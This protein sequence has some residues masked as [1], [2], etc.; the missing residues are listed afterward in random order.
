[1]VSLFAREKRPVHGQRAQGRRVHRGSGT[2]DE[3][4]AH[5]RRARAVCRSACVS[6]L[7]DAKSNHA[8]I[9]KET[10]TWFPLQKTKQEFVWR[11]VALKRCQWPNKAVRKRGVR[12]LQE[13]QIFRLTLFGPLWVPSYA[14]NLWGKYG[15][16]WIPLMV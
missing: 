8:V 11:T 2:D 6:A 15:N 12:G 10:T 14:E 4:R 9:N 16:W 3:R 13:N 5:G 7:A 1:M